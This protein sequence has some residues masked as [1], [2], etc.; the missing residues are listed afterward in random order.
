MLTK[1]I[2][3]VSMNPLHNTLSIKQSGIK[4]TL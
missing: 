1:H 4:R 2:M 3:F